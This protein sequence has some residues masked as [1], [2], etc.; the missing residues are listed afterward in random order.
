MDQNIV[1]QLLIRFKTKEEFE[2]EFGEK[3]R[4]KVKCCW[5]LQM[6]NHLGK[7][8]PHKFYWQIWEVYLNNSET[9]FSVGGYSYHSDMMKIELRNE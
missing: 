8:I 4:D 6:D 3:W 9:I 7:S 2:L 1:K 5:V